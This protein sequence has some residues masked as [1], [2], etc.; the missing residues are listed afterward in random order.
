MIEDK[1]WSKD[2]DRYYEMFINDQKI[3]TQI[4]KLDI[5]YQQ[6]PAKMIVIRNIN[7]I[8]EYEKIKNE[9]KYQELM[10]ATMSHEMLTPLNSI[11]NLSVYVEEKLRKRFN[12]DAE[13]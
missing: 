11:I 5:F 4:R 2:E 7:L 3:V 9:N 6:I 1:G 12:L 10:T 13:M 8:V